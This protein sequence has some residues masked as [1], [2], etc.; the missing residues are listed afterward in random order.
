MFPVEHS[1]S[2]LPY[3]PPSIP[4]AK[5]PIG[6]MFHEEQKPAGVLL[7]PLTLTAKNDILEAD[8]IENRRMM[9]GFAGNNPIKG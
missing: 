1:E 6:K 9:S 5:L 2:F 8:G 4:R 7:F 3:I